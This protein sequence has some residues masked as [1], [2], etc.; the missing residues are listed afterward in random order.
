MTNTN[1]LLGIQCEPATVLVGIG[2][3]TIFDAFLKLWSMF[4]DQ[5]SYLK[6]FFF[7]PISVEQILGTSAAR[8]PT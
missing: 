7:A 8:I 4:F 5:V 2:E 6:Q 3:S 1:V